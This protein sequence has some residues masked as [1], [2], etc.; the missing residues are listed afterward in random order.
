MKKKLLI[1]SIILFLF[2]VIVILFISPLTKYLVEKYDV[3]YTGREIKVGRSYVNPFTGYIHFSNVRFYEQNSDSVFLSA[4]G[5]RADISLIKLFSNT[6]EI[7]SLILDQ[8]HGI[9][10]QNKNCFNFSDL[11]EIF[12]PKKI[13]D[14]LIQPLHLNILNVTINDGEFIYNEPITPINYFISKMNFKSEGMSWNSDTVKGKFSFVPGKGS[15]DIKGNFMINLSNQ[16]YRLDV[17]AHQL[18]LEIIEQYLKDLSSYGTFSANIDAD[19]KVIGNLN[20]TAILNLKGNLAV[21]D[22]HLGK[23]RDED[24][25]YFNKLKVDIKELDLQS[26]KYFFDSVLLAGPYLKYEQYDHLDN[27]TRMFSN[28]D[29]TL[30]AINSNPDRFNLIIEI[31]RFI[32]TVFKNFLSSDYTI[33]SLAV[34]NG[35]ILFNDYSI[36]EKFSAAMNPLHIKAD[37]VDNTKDRVKVFLES[38]I[39]PFGSVSASVSMNPKDNSDFDFLYR[40]QNVPAAIFNPYLISYTSFPVDRGVVEVS[41]N[42]KVRDDD[43]QSSNHFLVIDARV[44]KR[45][46]KEDTKWIPMPLIMAFIRERGNVIDYDIPISGNMKNPK[47]H[48][49]DVLMD[50][51]GNIFIKPSTT[52]YRMDVK[53]VENEIEKLH[54]FN[55]AMRQSK[56]LPSQEKFVKQI[57]EFLKSTPVASIEVHPFYFAEKEKEYILIFEAKKKYFLARDKKSYNEMTES[58]SI[59]IDKMS[60]KDSSFVKYLDNNTKD[61][62]LFTI[63]E[64]CSRI[65]SSQLVDRKFDQLKKE[66]KRVFMEYFKEKQTDKQVQL[67][68]NENTVPFNGFSYYK[69]KYIGDIPKSLTLAYEKLSEMNAESPRKQYLNY[70][71]HKTE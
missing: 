6:F 41:G 66:R 13:I 31:G 34:E 45:I 38:K 25:V 60:S 17:V 2:I 14:T 39:K 48:L 68:E 1:I 58:D 32:K 8:P 27:F 62:M 5:I 69:I 22:F 55:W 9:I 51:L 53:N 56:L 40:L 42:W 4:G 63:Q 70:R 24:F 20:N 28:A 59:D 61:S 46:R 67:Y 26:K 10:I 7:N 11:I 12:S 18:D 3:K 36:N 57:S 47:F 21:N 15:G 37:S 19:L 44:T 23:N 65:I 64:K 71:K 35:N 50:L 30:E 29:S 33:N 16:D 43:I 49:H 52:P 54:T